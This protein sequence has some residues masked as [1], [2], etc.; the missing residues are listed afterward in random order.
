MCDLHYTTVGCIGDKL[1][2]L[3]N[4]ASAV[5]EGNCNLET[6]LMILYSNLRTYESRI[7]F[8]VP[9]NAVAQPVTNK[10]IKVDICEKNKI[11]EVTVH[12]DYVNDQGNLVCGYCNVPRHS[13]LACNRRLNLC[14]RCAGSHKVTDC[15]KPRKT[16]GRLTPKFIKDRAISLRTSYNP[17]NHADQII[18]P[19]TAMNGAEDD[20]CD[21][22]NSELTAIKCATACA[23]IDNAPCS[24]NTISASSNN[25]NCDSVNSDIVDNSLVNN[26]N[27]TSVN[28]IN[29]TDNVYNMCLTQENQCNSVNSVIDKF[30]INSEERENLRRLSDNQLKNNKISPMRAP[31]KNTPNTVNVKK[32]K[33]K[34]YGSGYRKRFKKFV[35]LLKTRKLICNNVE[36]RNTVQKKLKSFKRK[37]LRRGRKKRVWKHLKKP[38]GKI[39]ETVQIKYMLKN[40]AAFVKEVELH[41]NEPQ[42]SRE[43]QLE[44]EKKAVADDC[45]DSHMQRKYVECIE[46]CRLALLRYPDEKYFVKL[47]YDAI[48]NH[49][50][51]DFEEGKYEDCIKKCNILI[52]DC[53]KDKALNL[54]TRGECYMEL[55]KFALANEDYEE[56]CRLDPENR[57]DYMSL[58]MEN[59]TAMNKEIR[60]EEERLLMKLRELALM[61]CTADFNTYGGVVGR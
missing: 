11:P 14:F 50:I 49:L 61:D 51:E 5:R 13:Y 43:Q 53:P 38:N 37:I 35:N 16:Y 19:V 31:I 46:K 56:A 36:D 26:L 4:L 23:E 42:L 3:N 48:T 39:V 7:N 32:L 9:V 55:K 40:S 45:A 8:N 6:E 44:V 34:I 10:L 28:N 18:T 47:T 17:T 60:T 22:N 54:K 15:K 41:G 30:A 29:K 12:R 59:K 2:I 33:R 24:S 1:K 52:S 25:E 57:K 27:I 58:I 20:K 21:L